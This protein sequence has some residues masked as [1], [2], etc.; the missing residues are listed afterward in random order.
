M[1]MANSIEGRTLFLD[2]HL[3]S[4]ANHLPP[5]TKVHFDVERGTYTEKWILREAAEP[6]ITHEMY[7]RKKHVSLA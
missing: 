2:H 3:V 4:F 5:S 6:Y 7:E 1:E